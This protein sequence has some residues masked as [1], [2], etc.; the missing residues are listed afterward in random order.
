MRK[1]VIALDSGDDRR[2]DSISSPRVYLWDTEA[3]CS[4]YKASEL[5]NAVKTH[6]KLRSGLVT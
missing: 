3:S 5:F 4:N 6:P 2:G 1:L